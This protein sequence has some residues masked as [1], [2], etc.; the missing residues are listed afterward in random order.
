MGGSETEISFSDNIVF[1]IK[2]FSMKFIHTLEI[3]K[4]SR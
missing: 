1:E 3:S 2:S 4:V